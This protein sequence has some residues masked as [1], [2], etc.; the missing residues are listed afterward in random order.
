VFVHEGDEIAM[1][2]DFNV[3]VQDINSVKIQVVRADGVFTEPKVTGTR[4]KVK[5]VVPL[6]DTVF[7][8]LPFELQAGNEISVCV[9]MLNLGIN[10]QQSLADR[11]G[12]N[13]LQEI[14]NLDNHRTLKHYILRF[15]DV[16]ALADK[17]W[18]DKLS[19]A[20]T[21]SEELL[22]QIQNRKHKN[23]NIISIMQQLSRVL[24]AARVTSCKSAK[25]RTSMAVTLEQANILI[26]EYSM[27]QGVFQQA[28]DSMRSQGTRLQ[29]C[30]KNVGHPLYAFNVIQVT[31]LPRQYRPPDGTYRKLPT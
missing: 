8:L 5:I 15:R 6:E 23:T 27:D 21:L 7:H 11:I 16:F 29:N 28:L 2:E 3:A 26:R 20:E 18:K 13:T 17:K 25:D 31:A 14:I 1:L 24:N 30:L 22:G 10:E 19:K 9:V 12:D 4:Y